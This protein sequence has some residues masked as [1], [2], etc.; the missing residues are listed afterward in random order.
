MPT[1]VSSKTLRFTESVIREMTRRTLAR[2][3]VNLAQGF[4]DFPAPV[5]LKEAAKLAIDSDY[6][7]YAVTHGSANFRAAIAEKAR[8]YN[9]LDCDPDRNVTVT[10]GATEAMIASL[11]AVIN[12]GDEIVIFEPFYENYGPD[13]IL[14]GATPRYVALR[15]PNYTIDSDELEAAFGPRT[16]AVIINTPHNPTGKVF[17]RVELEA[18]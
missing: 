12:P 4:P 6:N 3:A 11:L 15:G 7:Q 2:G 14:A 13:T 1:E 9:G 8:S 16:K 18:I 10:C 17:S 5:E